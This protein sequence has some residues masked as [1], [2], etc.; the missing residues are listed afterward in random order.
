MTTGGISTTSTGTTIERAPDAHVGSAEPSDDTP[1]ALP[2]ADAAPV[3]VLS[4]ASCSV[5]GARPENEDRAGALRMHTGDSDTALAVV[6]DGMGGYAGGELAAREACAT[7]L[8][9]VVRSAVENATPD[10]P[11]SPEAWLQEALLDAGDSVVLR[12][13]RTRP[14]NLQAGATLCAALVHDGALYVINVGDSR[15]YVLRDGEARQLTRDDSYVQDLVDEGVLTPEEAVSHECANQITKAVC[16]TDRLLDEQ[17]SKH[18]LKP[19]DLV[20]VCSD[21]LWKAKGD[22]MAPALEWL[23]GNRDR[24][25]TL[26]ELSKELAVE[27]L[28]LESDDNISVALI[29]CGESNRNQGDRLTTPN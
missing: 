11:F 18:V 28:T 13:R 4:V 23:A 2:E 1:Q 17:V 14:C 26:D 16:A 27:A 22:V 10:C 15:A 20:L 3:D 6:M 25:T 9:R 7:F 21:G 24:A 29:Y 8:S 12:L 19:G 5:P